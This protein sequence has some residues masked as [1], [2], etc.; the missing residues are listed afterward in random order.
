MNNTRINLAIEHLHALSTIYGL[1]SSQIESIELATA[2][3]KTI[4][5]AQLGADT[6]VPKSTKT[7]IIQLLDNIKDLL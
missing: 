3:L 4:R 1:S 7:Q 5:D 2:A 6:L